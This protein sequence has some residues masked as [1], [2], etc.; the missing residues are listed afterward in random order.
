MNARAWSDR[1]YLTP[2][3]LHFI[4]YFPNE[5]VGSSTLAAATGLD[6]ARVNHDSVLSNGKKVYTKEAVLD[7]AHRQFNRCIDWLIRVEE[8]HRRSIAKNPAKIPDSLLW[9]QSYFWCDACT[10]VLSNPSKHVRNTHGCCANRVERRW[11]PIT[12]DLPVPAHEPHWCLWCHESFEQSE[13]D[14]HL[15]RRHFGIGK[16]IPMT[17]PGVRDAHPELRRVRETLEIECASWS[18]L[19]RDA[20]V[21]RSHEVNKIVP[22]LRSMSW[23]ERYV[24][25]IVRTTGVVRHCIRQRMKGSGIFLTTR[26]DHERVLLAWRE[27]EV[28]SILM[29]VLPDAI[30]DFLLIP[31]IKKRYAKDDEFYRKKYANT[32]RRQV[33]TCDRCGASSDDVYILHSKYIPGHYCDSCIDEDDELSRQ[34]H[35]WQ[36]V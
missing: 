36:D 24:C 29:S 20:Y 14:D 18:K 4:R 10:I 26:G 34:Y 22:I 12:S 30:V 15:A 9:K 3:C 19:W 27:S 25:A 2:E 6:A 5:I 1:E 17:V 31:E 28:R 35:R 16:S 33:W 8:S 13:I 7:A 11:I 32:K 21:V 23:N